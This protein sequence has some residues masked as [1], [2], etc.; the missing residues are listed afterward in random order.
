MQNDLTT[1]RIKKETAKTLKEIGKKGVDYIFDTL[2]GTG[3][4]M[5]PHIMRYS[6]V[7]HLYKKGF[8]PAEIQKL[9]GHKNI[10]TTLS[11]LNIGFDDLQKKFNERIK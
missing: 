1:I 2:K 11:Y 4:K 3:E 10:Q 6:Y 9:V 8:T 7:N 5:H